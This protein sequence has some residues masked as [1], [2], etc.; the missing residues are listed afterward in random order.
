MK[1]PEVSDTLKAKYSPQLEHL[2]DVYARLEDPEIDQ[3]TLISTNTI[4][5]KSFVKFANHFKVVP[6]IIA[7]ENLPMIFA[8]TTKGKPAYG[9]LA[10]KALSYEDF[11]EAI[12]KICILGKTKLGAAAIPEN[13]PEERKDEVMGPTFDLKGMDSTV[14]EKFLKHLGLTPGEK[15]GPIYQTLKKI[16][17]ENQ[18]AINAAKGSSKV[19]PAVTGEKQ[20]EEAKK[21]QGEGVAE[22]GPA[23]EPEPDQKVE[24][25]DQVVQ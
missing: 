23:Q 2:F 21:G 15:K 1:M 3:E 5:S 7:A 8:S 18:K 20:G 19:Q 9:K 12:V 25:N 13:P 14:I 16:K 24:G 4:Q 22:P 10:V 11:L 6:D 17:L